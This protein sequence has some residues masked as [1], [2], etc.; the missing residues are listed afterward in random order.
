MHSLKVLVDMYDLVHHVAQ[1]IRPEPNTL[2][3]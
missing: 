1:R 2:M 3:R